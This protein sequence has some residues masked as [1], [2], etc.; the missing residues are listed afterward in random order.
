[1]KLRLVYVVAWFVLLLL[2][3]YYF[4]FIPRTWGFIH[5]FFDAQTSANA[6][7][8]LFSME[9]RHAFIERP[10]DSRAFESRLGFLLYSQAYLLPL[11]SLMLSIFF[12][13]FRRTNH[14]RLTLICVS[15]AFG[16]SGA[17]VSLLLG[18]GYRV[19]F[20]L[21]NISGGVLGVALACMSPF[22][23]KETRAQ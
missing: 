10:P 4:V 5:L 11:T 3:H 20:L 8:S 1:M 13:C 2:Y 21:W 18:F 9:S 17:F 22:R 15:L 19:P 12:F 23:I 6:A 16:G 7:E 14:K